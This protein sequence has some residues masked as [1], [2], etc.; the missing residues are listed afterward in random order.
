LT[1][2]QRRTSGAC[3]SAREVAEPARGHASQRCQRP[4]AVQ[5][6]RLGPGRADARG[7]HCLRFLRGPRRALAIRLLLRCR[8]RTPGAPIADDEI[9][10][11]RRRPDDLHV[12]S[13]SPASTN[14]FASAC[15]RTVVSLSDPVVFVSIIVV[16]IALGKLLVGASL[17]GLGVRVVHHDHGVGSRG[18]L[19]H[20]DLKRR[21]AAKLSLR[22]NRG[23][24]VR[25]GP[26]SRRSRPGGALVRRRPRGDVPDRCAIGPPSRAARPS[27][28]REMNR[29]V[30]PS[31]RCR[32]FCRCLF[33]KTRRRSTIALCVARKHVRCTSC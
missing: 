8:H 16:R 26:H 5:N 12:L 7:S 28:E 2:V 10:V 31:A 19:R 25:S 11:A 21:K 24:L 29:C 33:W 13:G 22:A 15:A 30:C 4:D 17:E 9:L 27:S 18:H 14:R 3:R 1:P 20:C 32:Q 23:I 6:R